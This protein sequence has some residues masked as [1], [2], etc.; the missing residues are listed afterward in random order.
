MSQHA[1][2]LQKYNLIWPSTHQ[3]GS[4]K[5]ISLFGVDL[6]N[7]SIDNTTTEITDMKVFF[8]ENRAQNHSII[9]SSENFSKDSPI[10]VAMLKSMLRG[11]DVTIIYFYREFISHLLSV[12]YQLYH[13]N[14]S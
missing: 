1:R 5:G 8:E 11:F 3:Y 14:L 6:A 12:Y 9:I 2:D 7:D 10:G 4:P 13:L